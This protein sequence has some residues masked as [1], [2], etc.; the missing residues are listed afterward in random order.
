MS[1]VRCLVGVDI[2]M[3]NDQLLLLRNRRWFQEGLVQFVEERRAVKEHIHET[4]SS[5]FHTL[6]PFEMSYRVHYFLS[7]FPGRSSQDLR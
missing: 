4:G 2:G 3:L 6:N 1:D 5:R 7:N